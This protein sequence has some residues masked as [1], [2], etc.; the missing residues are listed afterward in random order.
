MAESG[1]RSERAPAH[2]NL[3]PRKSGL[4]LAN[5]FQLSVLRVKN[6][7]L[8]LSRLSSASLGVSLLYTGGPTQTGFSKLI[9][10]LGSFHVHCIRRG[11]PV[12]TRRH[13]ECDADLPRQFSYCGTFQSP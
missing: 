7:G 5:E 1:C 2:R 12:E 9:F 8:Y 10:Q 4:L 13:I 6:D 11:V 3:F